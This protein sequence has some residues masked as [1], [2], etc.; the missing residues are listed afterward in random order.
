MKRQHGYNK[1]MVGKGNSFELQT[2]WGIFEFQGDKS[3]NKSCP[4]LLGGPW[5]HGHSDI[6]SFPHLNKNS[7]IHFPIKDLHFNWATK[8]KTPSYFPLKPGCLTIGILISWYLKSCPH[9][10]VGS[11][12]L[13]SLVQP[14][15]FFHCSII[16]WKLPRPLTLPLFFSGW[17]FWIRWRFG[18]G[19]DTRGATYQKNGSSHIF[20]LHETN[21]AL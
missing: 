16:S 3:K 8:R 20:S 19:L 13:Y 6:T 4:L 18:G 11:H 17:L 21:I 15:F 10:W 5:I 7:H 9:K 1:M 12:P 2:I 14:G